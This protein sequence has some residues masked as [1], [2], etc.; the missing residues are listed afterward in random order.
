MRTKAL[1]ISVT[2]GL[3]L[4]VS[5]PTHGISA[6]TPEPTTLPIAASASLPTPIGKS[7]HHPAPLRYAQSKIK[8]CQAI[9]LSLLI[10]CR[11]NVP[12]R[13]ACMR[14]HETCVR[15]C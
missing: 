1:M 13:P 9:C 12:D 10:S 11:E 6:E 8:T 5:P 3:F 4:T 14:A 2:I 15:N 7:P